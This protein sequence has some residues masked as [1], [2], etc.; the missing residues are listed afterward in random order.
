MSSP[1]KCLFI[2][3]SLMI[4]AIIGSALASLAKLNAET[5]EDGVYITKRSTLPIRLRRPGLDLNKVAVVEFW[6]TNDNGGTWLKAKEV[7]LTPELR[8]SGKIRY[9]FSARL[10]GRYGFRICVVH[11]N[12][13]RDPEP[14]S[15]QRP[16]ASDSLEIDSTAP[17]FPIVEIDGK[18]DAGNP[19]LRWAIRDLYPKAQGTSIEWRSVDG[20]WKLLATDLGVHGTLAISE[21]SARIV[22][23]KTSDLAGN[24]STSDLVVVPAGKKP[25]RQSHCRA[26]RKSSRALKKLPHR[27]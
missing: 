16:A 9:R 5:T 22:R 25:R 10:D 23:L 17:E 24:N 19:V 3:R 11:K 7:V 13:S 20:D 6:T 8:E 27:P 21:T 15:G 12:G 14:R 2:P 18:D 1:V 4:A 26:S